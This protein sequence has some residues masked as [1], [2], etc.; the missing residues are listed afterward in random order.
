V[1]SSRSS[2]AANRSGIHKFL[3]PVNVMCSR[4]QNNSKLNENIIDVIQYLGHNL[5]A[6]SIH[7]ID[8]IKRVCK[9]GYVK[10]PGRHVEIDP[11]F[12]LRELSQRAAEKTHLCPGGYF[13][14]PC[15]L[16]V[17]SRAER[18]HTQQRF[19][20]FEAL[21]SA[22]GVHKSDAPFC[23]FIHFHTIGT[24]RSTLSGIHKSPKHNPKLYHKTSC[25]YLFCFGF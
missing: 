10:I 13:R 7:A 6:E 14:S 8:S 2:A 12:P 1:T 20:T 23:V 25:L 18:R 9:R 11:S 17:N 24:K 4:K 16:C 3:V 22:I 5:S 21:T 19:T 15:L